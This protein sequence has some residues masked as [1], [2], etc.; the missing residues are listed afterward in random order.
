MKHIDDIIEQLNLQKNIS[1]EDI[2]NIDL[3]MD[4]VIQLFENTYKD[5]KRNTE[6]KIMTKTMINNY[7]KAK[8]FFPI[9][10][11]KYSKEHLILISMI[12]HL[13]G[14]LS[15]NDIKATL[16]GLNEGIVDQSID[17]EKFYQSY[18]QLFTTNVEK[19]KESV[20]ETTNEL[21]NEENPYLEKVLLIST[22]VSTSNFYRRL[23]EKLIDELDESRS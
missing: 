19:F 2:P 3:Y 8:V 14:A 15:I 7:A 17:L 23:A 9:Q 12:Y 16:E 6:E 13:K 22:L 5:T 21:L 4:Q 10:N 1:L 18:L 11:K 20:M